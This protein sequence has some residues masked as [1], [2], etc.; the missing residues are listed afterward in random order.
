VFSHS[1]A[2]WLAAAPSKTAPIRPVRAGGSRRPA[3]AI[4]PLAVV[5]GCAA[6][7]ALAGC[8][9]GIYSSTSSGAT[10][11]T[12]SAAATAG[13]ARTGSPTSAIAAL[14]GQA[15]GVNSFVAKLDIHATGHLAADLSG[16]LTEQV[17]PG[18][19]VEVQTTVPSGLEAI[20][21][22]DTAYLKIGA[23]TQAGGKPW[24]KA[25]IGGLDSSAGASLAPIVQQLQAGNPLA[26][27]QMF[28]AATNVRKIGAATISGVPTTEYSGSYSVAA[29]LAKLSA[30]QRA[31][32]QSDMESSGITGTQFTVWADANHQVR[33]ISLV[34]VGKST[35][36]DIVLVIVSLNQPVQ[37]Q[38]PPASE[39]AG[40]TGITT[41]PAP[42]AT[43]PAP[44]M[45]SAPPTPRVTST[46][47]PVAPSQPTPLPTD[48]PTHW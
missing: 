43:T 30:S 28:A 8:K 22:G 47:T 19:L 24:I 14:A 34:E 11:F 39:V 3:Q 38:I 21:S 16:T 4:R 26:Q 42:V 23:L 10:P 20:L 33:K 27:S 5:L 15:A 12:P 32:L 36:I 25:S 44:A 13:T 17:Q 1:K 31:D 29:G 7:I 37:I 46:P 41:R 45:T 40:A 35:Q 9:P 2:R 18:P 6:A 48:Q